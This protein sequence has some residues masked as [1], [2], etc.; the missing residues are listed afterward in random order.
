MLGPTHPKGKNSY[1]TGTANFDQMFS[2]IAA[3][4]D[5]NLTLNIVDLRWIRTYI[6]YPD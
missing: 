6:T 4:F 5:S 1:C 3:C 2:K